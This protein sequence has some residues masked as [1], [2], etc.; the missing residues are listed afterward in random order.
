MTAEEFINLPDEE[1]VE[2]ELSIA[3]FV[4]AVTVRP[5]LLQKR[6]QC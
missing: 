5:S 4:A 3:E 6:L 2:K 1:V